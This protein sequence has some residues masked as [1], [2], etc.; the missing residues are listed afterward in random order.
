MKSRTKVDVEL[1]K[2][3][4][5]GVF[6]YPADKSIIVDKLVPLVPSHDTYTEMFVGLG[7]LFFRKESA[8]VSAINDID[9]D[10]AE[11]YRSMQGCSDGD[12]E[13]LQKLDWKGSKRTWE[14]LKNSKPTDRI[15]KIHKF[16]YLTRFSYGRLRGKSWDP[17]SD[18]VV[19]KLASRVEFARDKLKGVKIYSGHYA[20]P[21]AEHDSKSAFHFLDPP[22]AGYN[23]AIGENK[24]DEGEFRKKLLALKGRFLLTYGV[25]G[26]L[27]VS[28]FNVKRL[29]QPRTIRAMRGVS[30]DKYL[31]HLLVTNYDL[32]KKSIERVKKALGDGYEIDDVD[33]IIDSDGATGKT[34]VFMSGKPVEKQDERYL[35]DGEAAFGLC[36]EKKNALCARL[37]GGKT[38]GDLN[39]Q[40]E[41]RR[42]D[43]D[44]PALADV[45]KGFSVHGD[46]HLLALAMG[47]VARE[48][49]EGKTIAG[50]IMQRVW[51]ESGLQTDT[52]REYF[53]SKGSYPKAGQGPLL[54]VLRIQKAGDG[55]WVARLEQDDLTP[56]TLKLGAPMPPP[57]IAAIP[58]S[59]M[60]LVPQE[61]RYWQTDGEEARTK[62]DALVMSGFFGARSIALVEGKFTR[63]VHKVFLHEPSDGASFAAE[64][65]SG[66][67]LERLTKL[68]GSPLQEVFSFGS[69][70]V[71]KL[72]SSA[73]YYDACD[74]GDADIEKVVER[75]LAL[76]VPFAMSAVDGPGAREAFARAGRPF[77]FVPGRGVGVDAVKRV[78]VL[79]Q[80]PANVDGL[81]WAD[82]VAKDD[83]TTDD[84]NVVPS[85]GDGSVEECIARQIAGGRTEEEARAICARRQKAWASPIAKGT[86][87]R[88]LKTKDERYTLCVVLAP[89]EEDAQKDIYSKAEIREAS[90]TFMERFQNVGFM[91]RK[92]INQRARIVES[93]LAPVDF[94]MDKEGNAFPVSRDSAYRKQ[95]GRELVTQGTWLL[96]HR[97][98]DDELWEMIK[99]GEITGLSIGGSA[100]RTPTGK[101]D[102]TKKTVE[103]Q[104][105]KIDIDRPKG[106]EQKLKLPDGTIK[107]RTYKNDYGE[108]PGTLGGDGEGLDVFIGSD[109]KSPTVFWF[110]QR[111]KD[112]DGSW[113]FDEYKLVVGEHDVEAAKK[114]YVD[115][116]PAEYIAGVVKTTLEM[117]KALRGLEPVE[118]VK[119][120]DRI[121]R[122]V[123]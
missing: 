104:G 36:V 109:P 70:D 82:F 92:L 115:H 63:V 19:A 22:Y 76:S 74:V 40:F 24:F 118:V 8:D 43:V 50:E 113:G 59:L 111:K 56:N 121:T 79:S 27:D 64:A 33:A 85:Q 23:V 48:K 32:S 110:V 31:T 2:R 29:R 117:V 102:G 26:K 103:F 112:E 5:A 15:G 83:L 41:V 14:R 75:A 16:L 25:K 17:N 49:N 10:V 119:M 87:M 73:I 66:W 116:I 88:L 114:I 52:L 95:A 28:G 99:S 90:H 80:A 9:P 107:T 78:F 61:F 34:Y 65:G 122:G 60:E 100:V 57:G 21:L 6:G 55:G 4:A 101:S 77:R 12:I 98:S 120:L 89:E 91:H 71:A 81:V 47:V 58:K 62:R 93:Y 20:D 94:E 84:F 72:Q 30:Q 67:E 1:E 7:A 123:S 54:G 69:R 51:V 44:P 96:G 106:F 11:V 35:P 46:R 39:W 53:L 108:I 13:K 45:A 97:V 105:L 3:A 86:T 18:G 38:W 68:I 37:V 42:P